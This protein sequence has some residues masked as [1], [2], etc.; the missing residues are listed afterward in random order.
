MYFGD[1][2]RRVARHK[3]WR[4]PTLEEAMS[5]MKSCQ[6]NEGLYI[7]LIFNAK[8]RW[9]WT[10]DQVKDKPGAA[11]A[12]NFN[13][14]YCSWCYFYNIYVYMRAVRSMQSSAE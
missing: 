4:L 14:G 10:A 2:K 13:G 1:A 5:L 11:W 8:Q 3:D 9:I 6:N 7:D 12:V